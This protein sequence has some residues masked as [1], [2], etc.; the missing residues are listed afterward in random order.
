MIHN[1]DDEIIDSTSS[2]IDLN[3]ENNKDD[4]RNKLLQDVYY[5]NLELQNLSFSGFF[6]RNKIL[7]YSFL[8]SV[9]VGIGFL[10]YMFYG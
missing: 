2:T 7:I 3:R 1:D 4:M 9:C 10:I 8:F 6:K 5:E